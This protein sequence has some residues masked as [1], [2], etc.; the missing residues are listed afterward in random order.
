MD[1]VEIF[2]SFAKVPRCSFDALKMRDF[3][4]RFAAEQ[5]YET[6]IDKAD[7][8]ICRKKAPLICLQAHYDMVCLGDAPNVEIYEKDGWLRAKNSTLGAD[9][10]I[11]AALMLNMMQKFD[12]IECLFTSDEEVGLI[13]ANNLEHQ[14]TAPYLLNLDSEEE[15]AIVIGC[16]GGVDII[17][18]MDAQKKPAEKGFSAYEAGIKDLQGGHSGVDIDKNIPNAIKVLAHELAKNRCELVSINGGERMNSIPKSASAVIYAP[19][20]FSLQN[21]FNIKEAA[22]DG[23]VL[24]CS[25]EI[26]SMLY[27]FKQGVR[28][29]DDNLKIPHESIN[30]STIKTEVGKIKVEFFARAMEKKSLENLCEETEKFL[31]S[32]GF[33][34][35]TE[36]F[37]APWKPNITPFAQKIQKVMQNFFK[38]VEFK[39]MHAGLECGIFERQNR[40]LQTASVGPDICFPH[41]LGEKCN[42][43]S[44]ERVERIVEEIILELRR[45]K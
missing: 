7:N 33:R 31:K 35:K 26:I 44:I 29:F 8:I 3:I 19:K 34:V 42:I 12:D 17:A 16:A 37:S 30:L 22:A 11:G 28:S 25:K 39:A 36:G 13:G 23:G 24:T 4:V 21:G 2:K 20:N 40:S 32:F 45:E 27:G 5:G 14:I 41:S 38:S 18:E 43:S 15:G 10:G 1:T 6:K 9:N